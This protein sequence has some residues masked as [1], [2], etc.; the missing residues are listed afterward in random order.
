MVVA[1][2]AL[3]TLHESVDT[4]YCAGGKGVSS[5]MYK[6]FV[7][8]S[9]GLLGYEFCGGWFLQV[10]HDLGELDRLFQLNSL[11][12]S[13]DGTFVSSSGG[14]YESL[15]PTVAIPCTSCDVMSG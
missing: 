1:D 3:L 5:A 4:K 15:L 14:L 11:S 8:I 10:N 2:P 7:M 6:V 13:R 9:V 12:V